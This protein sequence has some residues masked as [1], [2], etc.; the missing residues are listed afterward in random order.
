MKE[1]AEVNDYRETRIIGERIGP[2]CRELTE[3]DRDL[4]QFSRRA[5]ELREALSEHVCCN[6]TLSQAPA[7]SNHE[8]EWPLHSSRLRR[9]RDLGH[10]YV[11]P[12]RSFHCY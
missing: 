5:E 10:H 3:T 11:L 4:V 12:G 7:M 1:P 6:A 8:A 2:L 9:K